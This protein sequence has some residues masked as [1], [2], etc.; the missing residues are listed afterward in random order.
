[1]KQIISIVRRLLLVAVLSLSWSSA[2]AV[3]NFEQGGPISKI[4]SARFV[5]EN[6]EYRIAPGARLKSF[7][8]S[9]RRLS[10]FKIG[11]VIIFQGKVISGVYYVDKIIY[12]PPLPS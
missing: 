9:R 12:Y 4:G 10:D 7:D 6:Q 8:N 1:M 11:D 3:E 2:G 5:V